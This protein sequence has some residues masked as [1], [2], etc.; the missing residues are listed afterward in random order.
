MAR[1][2]S[3]RIPNA[4]MVG[5]VPGRACLSLQGC[6][7]SL[8]G[9]SQGTGSHM[10]SPACWGPL[11]CGSA[12]LPTPPPTH[13]HTQ[14]LCSSQQRVLSAGPAWK[15]Q[16]QRCPCGVLLPRGMLACLPACLPA[17]LRETPP[18]LPWP[19]LAFCQW[20]HSHGRLFCAGQRAG[21]RKTAS[22]G[23]ITAQ[24]AWPLL[25]LLLLL[26]PNVNRVLLVE[27]LRRLTGQART[28]Y[29]CC[30]SSLLAPDFCSPNALLREQPI[31][32]T[33]W[34]PFL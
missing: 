14:Q 33:V 9:S 18:C 7:H 4:C 26:A 17:S 6:C 25:L 16:D 30:T 13:T 28:D 8:P 21:W 23:Q 32:A 20:S 1:S 12:S 15:Q 3:L 31:F 5:M 29:L 19:G 34:T 27:L 24:G 10:Q 11:P 22:L 2:P